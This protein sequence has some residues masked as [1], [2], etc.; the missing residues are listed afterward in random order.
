MTP[1]HGPRTGRPPARAMRGMVSS[2]HDLATA[3]SHFLE[4]G[5][6]PRGDGAAQG[7]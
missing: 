2:A 6:D 3:F 5:A 7:Y 4:G 1:H